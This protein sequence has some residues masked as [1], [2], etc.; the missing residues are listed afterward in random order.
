MARII[1]LGP[2]EDAVP[3][4]A[5]GA[6]LRETSDPKE[7]GAALAELAREASTALVLVPESQAEGCAE[8]IAE[9]QP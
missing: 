1:A 7:L 9:F 2:A 8:E 4:L 3:Y 6:E 5:M